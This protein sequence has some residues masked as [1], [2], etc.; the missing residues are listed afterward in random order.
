M[1][2]VLI[3]PPQHTRYPQPPMGLAL[4]GAILE[5]EGY[6]VEIIDLNVISVD[7]PNGLSFVLKMLKLEADAIGFTAMTPTIN[8]TLDILRHMKQG[9]RQSHIVL[10]GV[11]A[12]L[13]PDE[14]FNDDIDVLVKGQ[15]DNAI[16]EVLRDDIR[17]V[18]E[19]KAVVDLDSLPY[20]AYHLLPWQ[21]YKAH[22]PHGKALPVFPIIT[23]R[24]CP[25]KCAFCAGSVFGKKY[26]G[27]S[28]ERVVDEIEYYQ[29]RFGVREIT[30]YDDVF[31]MDKNRA[32][33]IAE[34]ILER[35]IK[36]L[37][38]CETRVDL[39]EK[40]LLE[41][42]KRAGCYSI[43]YGIESGTQE[44]LDSMC[45]GVTVEQAEEAVRMT[46]KVGIET[47]GYFMIGSPDETPENVLQ[48]IKCAKRL[49]LDY[50]QFSIT[51]PFPG[52]MLYNRYMGGRTEHPPWESFVYAGLGYK[53]SPVFESKHM[54]RGDIEMWVSRAYK[55]FYLR[56]SYVWQRLS[57]IR[58]IGDVKV[59]LKGLNMLRG[60]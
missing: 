42:M 9:A 26:R 49:K 32:Y 11:H 20:L 27:Q 56:P 55:G 44:I 3:N 48:T 58:S 16:L 7:A 47:V 57:G 39:V 35:H 5:R 17:G 28:A 33:E 45:K 52:T 30:F 4:L 43:A 34:E 21:D 38:T 22:P 14:T 12:T 13:L 15:G 29:K 40:E 25:Y 46:N 60:M 24:G 41:I 18:Y 19:S 51:T 8:A 6:Q 23:S 53:T 54:G 2:I 36:I 10:G 1:K 50:A 31:T 37:W 59:L